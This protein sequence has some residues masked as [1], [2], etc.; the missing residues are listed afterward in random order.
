MSSRSARSVWRGRPWTRPANVAR[1]TCGASLAYTGGS[2]S[3]SRAED[4]AERALWMARQRVKRERD[5]RG[6]TP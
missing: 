2:S 6:V 1:V 3:Y 5:L 4:D